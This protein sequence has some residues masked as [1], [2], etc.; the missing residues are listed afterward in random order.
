M[1][2][3]SFSTQTFPKL[4]YKGLI[5]PIVKNVD[6]DKL[7]PNNYRGIT[8][9]CTTYKIFCGV[10]NKRLSAWAEKN[11]LLYDEQNGFRA[12]R[13]C[14]DHV[15]SLT[16]ILETRI[17]RKQDTFCLFV[18][19]SKAYDRINRNKLWQKLSSYGLKGKLYDS[20]VSLYENVE[21]SVKLSHMNTI[22]KWF[23]V[24]TGLK[25]G[26]ILSPQLFNLYINDLIRELKDASIG[27]KAGDTL[28][29]C[30]AYADDSVICAKN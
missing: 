24:D 6:K 22:S 13:S 15:S 21:C 3:K 5:V 10:L 9:A 14:M 16:S 30:L 12:G 23:S 27:V 8:L 17:Q 1:F 11:G 19:F 2:N 20:L 18:D 25:Q 4:W 7:D 26:C 29:T 28:V